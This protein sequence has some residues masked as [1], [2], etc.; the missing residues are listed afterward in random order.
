VLT[1]QLTRRADGGGL[2]RCVRADGSFTWQKQGRH[3]AFFALHDLTH[4][5]VE[6]TLGFRG[7][8]FGLIADGWDI[9]DTTGKGARGPLPEEAREVEHIVGS[10]DMERAIGTLMTAEEFNGWARPRGDGG[11][12]PR[13][14]LTENEILRV[15]AKRGELFSRWASVA[16]GNTLELQ[17]D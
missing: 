4:L 14:E 1:I 6:S 16:A 8:F 11:E 3:A 7:G 5:A 17:F 2:L 12:A 13:R 15:R 10:F 9:E